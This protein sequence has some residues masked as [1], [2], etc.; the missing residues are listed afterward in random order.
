M[1]CYELR[2]HLADGHRIDLRG[3]DWSGLV[4]V[5]DHEHEAVQGHFHDHGDEGDG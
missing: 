2:R 3:W 1:N 4:T 5:H